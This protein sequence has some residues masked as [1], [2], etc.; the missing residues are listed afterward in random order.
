MKIGKII[1]LSM[2]GVAAMVSCSEDELGND[3]KEYGTLEP[4]VGTYPGDK[5]ALSRADESEWYMYED[6]YPLSLE[7]QPTIGIFMTQG[8]APMKDISGKFVYR[9]DELTGEPRW[10]SDI[11]V[12]DGTVY[13]IFGYM[14]ANN[15]SWDADIDP[16][17]DTYNTGAI[18]KLQK[19]NVVTAS[20]VSVVVGILKGDINDSNDDTKMENT[21]K[22]KGEKYNGTSDKDSYLGSYNFVG[23]KD[24][25]FIYLWLD[26]LYTCINFELNMDVDYGKLR[27]IK[28]KEVKL[29]VSA[30]ETYDVTVTLG[31]SSANPITNVLYEPTEG[32]KTEESTAVL[33]SST[34]GME[35]PMEN[36]GTILNVPGYFA[37]ASSFTGE[38][39]TMEVTFTYDLYTV[40]SKGEKKLEEAGRTAKNTIKIGQLLAGKTLDRGKI[41]TVRA[42]VQ[43]SY[44]YVLA[45]EDLNNPVFE[46]EVE[47]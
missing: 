31:T 32:A 21:V 35:I 7:N 5:I 22:N 34:E 47:P 8:N 12:E 4:V 16:N 40:N 45:D 44:L 30:V 6:L 25:N 20:D 13:N 19:L 3:N 14:S 33:F 37:P 17:G 41:F 2:I 38:D 11:A 36:T 27:I 29:A 26:H 9:K 1:M 24:K 39:Q 42:T 10:I 46:L 18:M 43:P 23:E 28:L 15:T